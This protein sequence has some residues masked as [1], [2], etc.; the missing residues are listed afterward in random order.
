MFPN[1]PVLCLVSRD[2]S[3]LRRTLRDWTGQWRWVD[4]FL[5]S[6]SS[7]IVGHCWLMQRMF[8]IWYFCRD[9]FEFEN[10]SGVDL[11]LI[12]LQ[13]CIWFW[14]FCRGGG[15]SGMVSRVFSRPS[16]YPSDLHIYRASDHNKVWMQQTGEKNPFHLNR[17]LS[18]PLSEK[19]S[20]RHE[21]MSW[22]CLI[23][24]ELSR[25]QPQMILNEKDIAFPGQSKSGGV[26]LSAVKQLSFLAAT[27]PKCPPS[28]SPT[29][30][31]PGY[32]PLPIWDQNQPKC[33][34]LSWYWC[35]KLSKVNVTNTSSSR[36]SPTLK[37]A[38]S[39][40]LPI[41]RLPI[42]SPLV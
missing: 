28:P 31:P 8:W 3:P 19:F 39:A 14:Y 40:F 24:F 25:I 27:P 30:W 18:S 5:N 21:T 33:N 34:R 36:P 26:A 22:S 15:R 13:G 10:F 6:R 32:P 16:R 1:V 41:L 29:S 4:I 38:R 2:T 23:Y 7:D 17:L 9:G 42:W 20:A 37:S 12:L 11:I 35:L